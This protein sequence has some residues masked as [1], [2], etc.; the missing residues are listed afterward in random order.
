MSHGFRRTTPGQ[1]VP[2]EVYWERG[3]Q[4]GGRKRRGEE[5]ERSG[6]LS[7]YMG[8]D[9]TQVKVG[10]E[11]SGFWECVAVALAIDVRVPVSDM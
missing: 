6:G 3:G 8:D 9:V 5:R 7:L 1:T 2:R 10:G 11:P 4:G